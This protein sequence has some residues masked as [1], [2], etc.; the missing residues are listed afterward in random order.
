M[1]T[2]DAASLP[3]RALYGLVWLC[4]ALSALLIIF[5]LGV[6]T[7]AVIQRYVLGTPLLWGDE[8]VGYVLVAIVMLGTAEA[9][10]KGDHIAIDLLTSRAGKFGSHVLAAWSDLAVLAFA[11]VLGW[12]SWIAIVFAYDFGEYSSGYIE[13]QTW[14][15]QLP[16]LIGFGAHCTGC[17]N[18][19][20][21]TPH[22]GAQQM[23]IFL[24]FA[25]LILLLLTGMPI[26]AALGLTATVILL[27]TEGSISSV[28][29]TVYDHLDKPILTTIPLFVFMA[30][31]MVR[32]KVIDDLYDM[33]HTVVGHVRGGLGVATVMACTI[34]A[35]ISGSSVATA[36]S[37]GQ[38]ALPQMK[39]FGYPTRDALGVIAAG[40]SA[41]H[42]HSSVRAN[43]PLCHRLRGLDRCVVPRRHRSRRSNGAAVRHVLY[44]AGNAAP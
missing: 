28:A 29:T 34:F 39:R 1:E 16:M 42:S 31:V 20:L 17:D 21:R 24:V 18:A 44:F 13:I 2:A 9:L 32:A 19:P 38:S 15:P 7:Y 11:I 27:L 8:F 43:D 22:S 10:R 40:G 12:S 30:Q 35:A 33:A 5:I 36:L 3:A 6:V 41:R 23:T 14:I 4:G 25:G 37:I 26:F